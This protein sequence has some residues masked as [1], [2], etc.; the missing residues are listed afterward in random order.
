MARWNKRRE[1]FRKTLTENNCVYPASVYD[2]LSA[3]IAEDIGFEMGM[4]AGSLASQAV[5]GAPDLILLTLTEFA[6][7][8][9]RIG[10]ASSLPIFADADHGYGNALNVMRAIE[11]LESCGIAGLSIEDTELPRAYGNTDKPRL[12]SVEEGVGKMKAALA[13]RRD[14]K[15]VIAGRTSAPQL[16]SIEDTILRT[17]AY[18]KE[19]VDAIFLVGVPS[20]D[21]LALISNELTVPI[22]L[23]GGPKSLR[24]PKWLAN[25][26]VRFLL[27]GH[28]TLSVSTL[29]VYKALYAL[30]NG[31]EPE[32]IENKVATALLSKLT[33]SDYYNGLVTEWLE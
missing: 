18:E 27:R 16:T 14:K 26:G 3:L 25:K 31:V 28:Q 8:A 12:L 24:D 23:S 32:E 9:R 11:E 1:K 10:R 7:Q 20:R 29:A 21:A 6:E 13:G 4:L 15:M 30:R 19:G 33:R 22:L 17:K 2:P 5:L